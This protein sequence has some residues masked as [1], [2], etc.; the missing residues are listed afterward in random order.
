MDFGVAWN[1]RDRDPDVHSRWA[2]ASCCC[3]TLGFAEVIAGLRIKAGFKD[4]TIFKYEGSPPYDKVMTRY[5]S[6]DFV[7]NNKV[8]EYNKEK[9]CD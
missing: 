2:E 7:K 4:V 1:K 9:H 3:I 5:V 8:K 6:W